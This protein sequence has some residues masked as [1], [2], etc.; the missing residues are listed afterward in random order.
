MSSSICYTKATPP[1]EFHNFTFLQLANVVLGFPSFVYKEVKDLQSL[2]E[3]Q[4]RERVETITGIITM[5]Q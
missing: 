5:W 3:I 1:P 4:Q 2:K